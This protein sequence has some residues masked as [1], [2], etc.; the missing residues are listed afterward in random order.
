MNWCYP[1]SRG[2]RGWLRAVLH[3]LRLERHLGTHELRPPSAAWCKPERPGARLYVNA[4]ELSTNSGPKKRP[5]SRHFTCRRGTSAKDFLSSSVLLALIPS[6][7][8]TTC[9]AFYSAALNSGSLCSDWYLHLPARHP[10]SLSAGLRAWGLSRT[11]VLSA[12]LSVTQLSSSEKFSMFC[13]QRKVLASLVNSTQI[14]RRLAQKL[15]NFRS[16]H[17]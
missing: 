8:M 7:T 17:A 6:G 11:P 4:S 16:T 10:P 14:G 12:H 9:R 5:G 3:R 2:C 13:P 15:P 1:E